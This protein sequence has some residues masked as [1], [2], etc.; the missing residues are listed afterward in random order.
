[1]HSAATMLHTARATHAAACT[2]SGGRCTRPW[3]EWANALLVVMVENTLGL[4]CGR[5]DASEA[6]VF[7]D[8]KVTQPLPL[9]W[10]LC[11]ASCRFAAMQ[12]SVPRSRGAD[13]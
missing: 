5:P 12:H 11:I 7:A 6:R 10:L 2:Q 13:M 4:D 8:P 1:M 9:P 3:F